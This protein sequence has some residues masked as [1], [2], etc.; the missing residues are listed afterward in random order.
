MSN[1][2]EWLMGPSPFRGEVNDAFIGLLKKTRF[3]EYIRRSGQG[4]TLILADFVDDPRYDGGSEYDVR[5][6]ET[7][8]RNVGHIV[9]DGH[10]G[11]THTFASN[12]TA[13]RATVARLA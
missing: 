2:P 12:G 4:L 3:G 9:P 5:F 10:G 7:G 1:K 6:R 8:G 13:G 11:Q